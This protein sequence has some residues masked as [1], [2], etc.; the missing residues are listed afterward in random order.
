MNRIFHREFH[1]AQ[2]LVASFAIAIIAGAILLKLP[3][4]VRG[5]PLSFIDALFT[6][7]SAVCVTGL[8]VVDTATKFT[9]LGQVIILI[10]IQAGGLGIMTFSV[11]FILMAGKKISFRERVMIQDSFA[12]SPVKDMKSLVLSILKLT[13]IV[14]LAGAL[15]LFFAWK[16]DFSIG[17]AIFTSIFHSVSAFCNAGFSLFSNNLIPY[18]NS[19]V[20]NFT[21][22]ILI[23]VGGLGFLVLM[24][25]KQ[26]FFGLQKTQRRLSL[27]SKIVLSISAFLIASGMVIFFFIEKNISLKGSSFGESL[28]ASFFQSVTAR[29]AGFN[30]IDFSLLSPEMLFFIMILMFIGASPG[31]TGGGVKTTT[32]GV[33]LALIKSSFAGR[34]NV[35]IFKRTIPEDVVAR[36]LIILVSSVLLVIL[37]VMILL[38]TEG[39]ELSL[40]EKKGR[41]MDILF[42]AL[43]A[44]GT[45]GLSTGV[46]SSLTDWGKAAITLLMFIGRLGPLTIALAIGRKYA[47]GKFQYSDERVMTG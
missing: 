24:D 45:V 10:L 19:Y 37:F 42:E 26:F 22:A 13:L 43:S 23:I 5:V 25:I 27:H 14:E 15:I 29:T 4:M 31:S 44:F 20:V 11:L 30:T 40:I 33:L 21:V 41:F 9:P 39:V 34:K 36:S 16:D 32:V 17:F 1:P 28:L 38:I 47:P 12:H 8:I 2:V 46:T 6:A 3:G 18:M 7:T 35:S